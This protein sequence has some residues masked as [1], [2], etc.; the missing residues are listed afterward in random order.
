MSHPT[1]VN[2]NENAP[3]P[4][5]GSAKLILLVALVLLAAGVW[6]FLRGGGGRGAAEDKK[7]KVLKTSVTSAQVEVRDVA[8]SLSGLGT[9][10]PLHA[11]AVKS[12]VDGQLMA[13]HYKEGQVVHEG[14]LL[15]VIDERP[16]KAQLEQFQGQL[17]RD[18]AQLV[19]ARL[20]L[21]RYQELIRINA[22]PQQQLDTQAALVRQLEGAVKSDQGQVD[23]ARLQVGYCRIA[24]PLT[25]R[26]G[27]RP[28]DPGNMVQASNQVLAVITQVQ[29]IA[30]IFTIPEDS[31][32]GVMRKMAAGEQP[33][34]EAYDRE[35]RVRLAQGTLT[36]IDNQIDQSTGTIRLK[37]Q[38]DNRG[39][40]LFPNQFVNARIMAETIKDALTVPAAAV[41]RGQGTSALVYVVKEDDT[42]EARQVEPGASV[43]GV[44]VIRAGL[45][46]GESVVIEGGDK[47]RDGAPVSVKGENGKGRDGGGAGGETRPGA[48]EQPGKDGGAGH[49]SGTKARQGGA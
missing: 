48:P 38:F 41:Q 23:N 45:A 16:F 4:T 22:I 40:E 30:V 35:Q 44:T 9:V 8:L 20:D 27:L 14:D 1:L 32:P 17:A 11:V 18:E 2:P 29:P 31:L 25:G 26:V 19:N 37:A 6:W 28:V 13:V 12:R 47:L 3:R 36:S 49:K 39:L 7:P 21:K 5:G 43:G 46:A 42:V 15:A 24:A 33:A 34:V 10:V